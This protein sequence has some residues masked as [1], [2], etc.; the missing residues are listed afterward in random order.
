MSRILRRPMFRGG[1]INSEGT[2]ITSGLNYQRQGYADGPDNQGVQSNDD[3]MNDVFMRTIYGDNYDSQDTSNVPVQE[4]VAERI[5]RQR[6][7]SNRKIREYNQGLKEEQ[8]INPTTVSTLTRREQLGLEPSIYDLAKKAGVDIESGTAREQIEKRKAFEEK[9][10]TDKTKTPDYSK[11]NVL[12]DVYD[13]YNKPVATKQGVDEDAQFD[14]FY[15]RAY[16]ALGGEKAGT[17][18]IYDA[19]LAASPGF[20]RGRTLTE[21]AP[22]VLE[23]INK[24]GAFDR[25]QKLRQAAAELALTRQI[26]LEKIQEQEK[27]RSALLN[28]KLAGPQTIQNDIAKI[29]ANFKAGPNPL[30]ITGIAPTAIKGVSMSE[31]DKNPEASAYIDKQEKGKLILVQDPNGTQHYIV[32]TRKDKNNKSAWSYVGQKGIGQTTNSLSPSD[33]AAYNS[34]FRSE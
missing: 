14:K 5:A 16:K 8:G 34:S 13:L 26:G 19:M 30:T 24:S 2:G 33:L 17:Q 29:Q 21:A 10:K 12:S 23:G 27:A 20:F 7:E 3:F 11:S 15:N 25:P 4:T 18:A 32:V 28:Q 31:L 6:D 1:P 9:L 22:N